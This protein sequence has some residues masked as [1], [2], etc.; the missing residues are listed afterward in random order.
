MA[1]AISV[2]ELKVVKAKKASKKA[3]KKPAAKKTNGLPKKIMTGRR[4]KAFAFSTSPT[5][6]RA[7]P[8]RSCWHGSAPT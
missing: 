4:S 6:S 3:S 1:K 2:L 7:R 8:A 5:F